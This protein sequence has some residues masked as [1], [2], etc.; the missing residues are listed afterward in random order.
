M[1]VSDSKNSSIVPK[2]PGKITNPRAY[3]TNITLRM[4]K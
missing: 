1:S 4:K 2:P 3:F